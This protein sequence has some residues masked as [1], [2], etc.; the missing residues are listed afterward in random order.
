MKTETPAHVRIARQP[1]TAAAQDRIPQ[2]INV[3]EIPETETRNQAEGQAPVANKVGDH[4]SRAA[5]TEDE[6]LSNP[7]LCFL[8]HQ[9]N[10]SFRPVQAFVAQATNAVL[11]SNQSPFAKPL[12]WNRLD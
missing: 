11:S 9:D 10:E 12:K 7:D 8:E 5:A 1:C 3:L 6:S 4:H 2:V